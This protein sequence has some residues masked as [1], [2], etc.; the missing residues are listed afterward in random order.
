MKT[1]KLLSL[2]LC[3]VLLLCSVFPVFARTEIVW[4]EAVPTW[5]NYIETITPVGET[6]YMKLKMTPKGYVF[7][8]CYIPLQYDVAFKDGTTETFRISSQPD[9]Y[10]DADVGYGDVSY[11]N[12]FTV[13]TDDEELYMVVGLD[14]DESK[15]QGLFFIEQ[16]VEVDITV[17]GT[18]ATGWTSGPIL[19]E[20]CETETDDGNYLTRLLYA[21]YSLFWETRIFF[22]TLSDQ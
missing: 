1:K 17:N 3:G 10:Y 13:G 2:L 15:K 22:G 8:D 14:Y 12:Y 5:Q 4:E 9:V 18:P 19:T 20:I 16:I 6:P 7:T 11:Y 21:F